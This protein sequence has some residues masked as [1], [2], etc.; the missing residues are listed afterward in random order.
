[1]ENSSDGDE[2]D[3]LKA[4]NIKLSSGKA[5][6]V[7]VV[8]GQLE[9]DPS[10]YQYLGEGE[11]EVI[12]YTY[13]VVE[14]EG[15]TEISRTPTTA[16]ITIDGK[17]DAP[18]A[19]DNLNNPDTGEAYWTNNDAGE[20]VTIPADL[21]L[22]N[23]S[24]ADKN[25]AIKIVLS[26]LKLDDPNAGDFE[27][28][29]KVSESETKTVSKDYQ[30]KDSESLESIIFTPNPDYSGQ[31]NLSYQVTD[32]MSD[33]NIANIP[34]IVNAVHAN[35][36][37]LSTAFTASSADGWQNLDGNDYFT[38]KALKIGDDGRRVEDGELITEGSE[39]IHK[40]GIGV[41]DAAR[42]DHTGASYQIEHNH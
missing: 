4:E 40:L 32:G 22:S 27:L 41:A 2:G 8:D 36:D 19:G 26:S 10:A 6:G 16:T 14:Y 13:D 33:S 25:N 28:V 11:K 37:G 12:T 7:K 30:L 9:V 31:V 18:Q 29:V 17:N 3:Q 38:I 15:D 23:A 24:D 1:L 39:H 34:I 42:A 21:I 5:D 35:N 20:I